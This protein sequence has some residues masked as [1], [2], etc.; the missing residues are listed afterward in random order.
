[1]MTKLVLMRV[2]AGAKI[3]AG[4]MMRCIALGQ[5]WQERGGDVT[6]LSNCESEVLRRGII[7]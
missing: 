5:T 2:D 1:M 4:H 3:G 6:F 7:G